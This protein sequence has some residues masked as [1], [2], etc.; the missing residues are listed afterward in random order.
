RNKGNA[1]IDS[2]HLNMGGGGIEQDVRIDGA[3]LVLND[4]RV[5][6]RIYKLANPLLPGEDLRFT[7]IATCEPKGFE[8]QVSVMQVNENGTFFNNMDVL[9]TIGYSARSE[10]QDRNERRKRGLPPKER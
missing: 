2:L 1:P 7:V 6:Y 9:P 4:E 10:M 3:E 5:D 8:N